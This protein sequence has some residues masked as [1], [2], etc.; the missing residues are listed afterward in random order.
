MPPRNKIQQLV[1][2]Q[3][4]CQ[5]IILW[6]LAELILTVRDNHLIVQYCLTKSFVTCGRSM[7]T[8]STQKL[9]SENECEGLFNQNSK[10]FSLNLSDKIKHYA[11]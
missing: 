8:D 2:L 7:G 3:S 1:K 11:K 6:K 4:L 9:S 10:N 5:K